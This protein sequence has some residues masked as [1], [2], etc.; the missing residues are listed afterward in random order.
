M[1]QLD[2]KRNSFI[3]FL[4]LGGRFFVE[5]LFR[6]KK[7][8]YNPRIYIKIFKQINLYLKIIS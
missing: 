7:K 6:Q 2:L 3:F 5:Y 1:H 8:T 4:L